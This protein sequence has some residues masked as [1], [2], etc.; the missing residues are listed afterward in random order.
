[1]QTKK[2]SLLESFQNIVVGYAVAILSQ[3]IIFPRFN[4]DIPLSDNLLIGCYFSI[5][6]IGRSYALRRYHN[7]KT[8]RLYKNETADTT[9]RTK[10]IQ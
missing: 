10:F 4:I 1:M 2:H 8:M 6:S 5:I 3:V 9:Y 7:R